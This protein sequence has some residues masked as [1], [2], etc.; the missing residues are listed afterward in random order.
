MQ[1]YRGLPNVGYSILQNFNGAV[2]KIAL[3][4]P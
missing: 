2:P 3:D 4:G 1:L